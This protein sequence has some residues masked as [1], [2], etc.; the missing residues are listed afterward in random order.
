M[1]QAGSPRENRLS[2]WWLVLEG[3]ADS[4][5]EV[6]TSVLDLLSARC[7]LIWSGAYRQAVRS[8]HLGF[9]VKAQL[10][11]KTLALAFCM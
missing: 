5:G 11:R 3:G 2:T 8:M 7:L 6:G 9:R 4:G 1:G 10:E